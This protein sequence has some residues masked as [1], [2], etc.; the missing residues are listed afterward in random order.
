MAT[1]NFKKLENNQLR[2]QPPDAR[3][4]VERNVSGS[5]GLLSYIGRVV[6][7]YI[8]RVVDMI[9][10]IVGGS[11]EQDSPPHSRGE[12]ANGPGDIL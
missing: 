10:Y 9:V 4:S 6:E 3:E 11:A 5:L 12:R 2:N 1:N 7:L 8:P